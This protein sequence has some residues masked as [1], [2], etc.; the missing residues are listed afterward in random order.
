MAEIDR[1]RLHVK[2]NILYYMQ[3]IWRQEPPDQRFFRLYDIDVPIV[4]PASTT[5]SVTSGGNGGS[6]GVSGTV[7]RLRAL[8][9]VTVSLPMPEVSLVKKK[10]VD[11]ADLDNVLAYKGNYMVFALKENNYITL[12]MMQDYLDIDETLGLRDPDE[13]SNYSAEELHELA[14]CVK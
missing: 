14:A 10:L 13:L 6:G 7:S 2:E 5:V 8:D 1:L 4:M 3:A 9:P 12:H 11:V